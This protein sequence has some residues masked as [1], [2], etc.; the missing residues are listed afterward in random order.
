ML[1]KRKLAHEFRPEVPDLPPH[2]P[3]AS[4]QKTFSSFSKGNGTFSNRL[5]LQYHPLI[6][7]ESDRRIEVS[8]DYHLVK[9][10]VR[11]SKRRVLE[12]GGLSASQVITGLAES[13]PV[14]CK[15]KMMIA[16]VAANCFHDEIVGD[17][18]SIIF[19]DSSKSNFEL[20]STSEN[21]ERRQGRGS[22]SEARRDAVLQ[23]GN[24]GRK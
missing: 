8:C 2:S 12:A 18:F 10:K 21:S 24:L 5:I 16:K 9:Q 17:D 23:G 19:K 22:W 4:H 14:K 1:A 13:P 20:S 6:L 11:G 15:Q 7:K 3:K